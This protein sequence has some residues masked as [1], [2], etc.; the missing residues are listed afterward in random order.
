MEK[1]RKG[2]PVRGSQLEA[3]IIRSLGGTLSELCILVREV[4][5]SVAW[6]L[7]RHLQTTSISP[8]IYYTEKQDI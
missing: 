7:N 1:G 3:E 2:I 4:A 6:P 8:A 5:D